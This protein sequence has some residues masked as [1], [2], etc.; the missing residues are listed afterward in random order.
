ME[1]GYNI[2]RDEFSFFELTEIVR[3]QGDAQFAHIL[4]RMREGLHTKKDIAVMRKCCVKSNYCIDETI[5]VLYSTNQKVR[6]YNKTIYD[7]CENNK[8]AI[9]CKQVV[10][11]PY[12]E[13]RKQSIIGNMKNESLSDTAGL[14]KVSE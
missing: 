8:V 3:Q 6:D 14:T 9:M 2:W 12:T 11:G 1:Y 13:I 7:R 5:P 10:I 4:N